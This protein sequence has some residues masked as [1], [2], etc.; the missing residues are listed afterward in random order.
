[1]LGTSRI[2]RH[3]VPFRVHALP[4][5][6]VV[7]ALRGCPPGMAP[8]GPDGTSAHDARCAPDGSPRPRTSGGRPDCR[9]KPCTYKTA[10]SGSPSS[11]PTRAPGCRRSDLLLGIL[12]A[13][14]IVSLKRFE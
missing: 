4:I 13:Y 8:A 6:D 12:P 2:T 10:G 14:R 1:L 11:A 7:S 5:S 9:S 3:L